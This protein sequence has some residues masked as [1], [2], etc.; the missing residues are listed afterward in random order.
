VS[1][2][3]AV[4]EQKRVKIKTIDGQKMKFK[5]IL[6][7]SSQYYGIKKIKGKS[8]RFLIQPNDI[9]SL[10][11]HNKTMSIIYGIGI[12]IVGVIVGSTIIF[13]AAW[14]GIGFAISPIGAW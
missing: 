9:E 5:R 2:D 13:L 7:D 4:T 3:K 6:L 14:N 1:L 11:L 12:G 8:K 10:R